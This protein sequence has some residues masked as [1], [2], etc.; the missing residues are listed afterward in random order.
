MINGIIGTNDALDALADVL[1][2]WK[3]PTEK[4]RPSMGTA[5]AAGAP[6]TPVCEVMTYTV[7]RNRHSKVTNS[8]KLKRITCNKDYRLHFFP[9]TVRQW[10]LHPESAGGH[11]SCIP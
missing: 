6:I 5:G 8:K 9:I 7:S 2:R 3:N 1:K 4:V 10:N 11:N